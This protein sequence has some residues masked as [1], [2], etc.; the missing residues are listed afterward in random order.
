M[1]LLK[2][3]LITVLAITSLFAPLA[4]AQVAAAVS[5][6]N[7]Y[8]SRGFDLGNGNAQISG[9]LKFSES[10]FYAGIWGSSGDSSAGTEYDLYTGY[11]GG[12]TD[13][14]NYDI[15]LWTYVYPQNSTDAVSAP[16]KFSE[17]IVAL[18]YGPVKLTYYSNLADQDDTVDSSYSYVTLDFT[19]EQFSILL[20]AH[21]DLAVGDGTYASPRHIDINYSYNDN[22]K[23]TLGK[24]LGTD[25]FQSENAVKFV[26][27]YTLPLGE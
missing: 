15:S 10:G 12:D 13:T 20:G 11:G 6:A 23:F 1:K 16:G 25:A 2:K 19:Y 21:K 17:A 26:A 8:Y 3:I 27:S 24:L 7:M 5:I 14:F 4:R 9:D 22:L 18:G